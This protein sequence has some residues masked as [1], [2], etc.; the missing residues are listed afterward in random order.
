MRNIKRPSSSLKILTALSCATLALSSPAWAQT[1]WTSAGAT[2]DWTET[3]NWS[4]GLPGDS[5]IVNFDNSY[6]GGTGIPNNFVNTPFTIYGLNYSTISTNGFHHTFLAEGITLKV[7]NEVQDP[8]V[9]YYGA[10]IG[11]QTLQYRVSGPGTLSVSNS[12]G[13]IDV[14]QTGSDSDH[15]AI[16]DLT[17]L[18]N[19][20]ADVQQVRIAGTVQNAPRAMGR[21]I[22]ART[23]RIHTASSADRPGIVIGAMESSNTSLRGTQQL[24]LGQHNEIQSD[25]IS[26]GAHKSTGAMQFQSGLNTPYL[27]LRGSSGGPV[28]VLAMADQRAG[29][30]TM[31]RTGTSVNHSGTLNTSGGILD[32]IAIETFVGRSGTNSSSTSTGTLTYD[33]GSLTTDNLY[34]GYHTTGLPSSGQTANASGTVNV[35]GTAILNVNNNITL[36]R[37]LGSSNPTGN[38]N[39]A[40]NAVVN[41]K[42]SIEPSGSGNSSVNNSG[43]I[44]LQPEGDATKGN[45]ASGTLTGFGRVTNANTVTVYSTLSPGTGMAAGQLDI[46]GNF[47]FGNNGGYTFNASSAAAAG[48]DILKVTGG[49]TLASNLVSLVPLGASL[50]PGSYRLIEYQGALSGYL[51][52]V[53]GTRYNVDLD[54]STTNQI[55]LTVTGGSPESLKWNSASSS[56]WDSGTTNWARMGTGTADQ[57]F[58]Y[59]SVLFDS[60]PAFTNLVLLNGA[61]SPAAVTVDAGDRNYSFGGSGRLSGGASLIKRGTGMLTISNAN[62]FVGGVAVEAGVLRTINGSALGGTNEGTIVSSGATLDIFG[63][64]L[65]NPGESITIGGTGYTNQGAIVNT[66]PAQNNAIRFLTLTDDALITTAARW[67]VRGPS[68]SGSFSG[69]LDLNGHTLTKGGSAQFSIVDSVVTNAGTIELQ[70]GM[71]GLTRSTIGGSGSIKA[72]TNI[73]FLENSST[74]SIAK[75]IEFTGGTLRVGG[76]ATYLMEPVVSGL[77]ATV[78]DIISASGVTNIMLTMSNAITGPGDVIKSNTATLMLTAPS[79]FTG[80]TLVQNGALKLSAAGSVAASP[81]ITLGTLGSTGVLDVADLGTY[82]LAAGQKLG[83]RGIILGNLTVQNGAGLLPGASAGVLTFSNNLVLNASESVF[84]LGANPA[85]VG[86]DSDFV[87]V[88]GD[89]NLTGLNKIKIAPLATLDNSSP[90]T[91]F[92][93]TG[94][95]VGGIDNLEISSDSRYT[96]TPAVVG[97]TI[98]VTVSG[99]GS[100]ASLVWEGGVAGNPNLW[101]NK[102]VANW[103]R[104][105]TPDIF[106]LGDNVTFNDDASTGTVTVG[107]TVQPAAMAVDNSALAYV[108]NGAGTIVAGSLAKNGSGSL[109]IGNGGLAV[110]GETSLTQ[111]S[112]TLTAGENLFGPV[113]ISGGSFSVNNASSTFGSTVSLAGG[114]FTLNPP[115]DIYFGG[116]LVNPLGVGTGILVKQGTSTVTLGGDNNAYEGAINVLQG[117]LKLG[118]ATAL[119]ASNSGPTTVNGGT[120]DLNGQALYQLGESITISGMGLNSTGA[121]I[122]TGAAVQNGLS[123]ITL[124][125]NAAVGGTG[126]WDLRGPSGSSS[127]SAVLSLGTFTLSKVGPNQVGLVDAEISGDGRIDVQGGI[128][129][130]TRCNLN[131]GGYIQLNTNIL[132]LENYSSGSIT[133]PLVSSGGTLRVTGNAFR[134]DG[135]VTNLPGGLIVDPTVNITLAGTVQ[136]AGSL[137]KVNSGTL[138]LSALDNNWTGGTYINAGTLQVGSGPGNADGSIPNLP[139][140]NSGTLFFNSSGT[141]T[142][143]AEISGSGSLNKRGEYGVLTIT[144]SNSFTGNINTGTGTSGEAGGI[145]LLKNSYGFGNTNKTANIIRAE[146]QLDG[147]IRI[148]NVIAFAT[149]AN[150]DATDWAIGHVAIRNIGGDNIVDGP[151]TLTSGGG[152]S[153]FVSDAGTLTLNGDVTANSTGRDLILS[154]G[155]P[156]FLNGAIT[157]NGANIPRLVKRGTNTWTLTGQ[158]T[159]TGPTT[160][161]EGTLLLTSAASLAN[162]TG[163][164][165]WSNGVLNIVAVPAFTVAPNSVIRGEGLIQGSVTVDGEI[166]AGSG[167]DGVE[168]SKL[169]FANGLA[170]RGVTTLQIDRTNAPVADLLAVAGNLSLGGT[171]IVTN[172]GEPLQMGD[173]FNLFDAA[174][175][176][177]SFTNY[178]LPAL[179]P[180]MGWDLSKLA[181]DGTITVGAPTST[182][183]VP[184]VYQVSASGIEFTWPVDHKGWRLEAQTNSL[185]T[186]L[187]NNWSTVPGSKD[188]NRVILGIDQASGSVFYRLVYP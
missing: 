142:N 112:I 160:V 145:I 151:I 120:L 107:G 86:T 3:G 60:T 40:S 13:A 79:T 157:N 57:F 165:T 54:Y 148:P 31:Y 114:T 100:S 135:A 126:R 21:M 90:Y 149:S 33:Q 71:L 119:G 55:S 130:M 43:I 34:I 28:Q 172:L 16:L 75:V 92:R 63:S 144:T 171:L 139:V 73:V 87:E 47:V 81:K 14:T 78:F 85:L 8:L 56:T 25:I 143:T 102:G 111:G 132:L 155:A 128:L 164:D 159:F 52:F 181:V 162:S 89:L 74:G 113:T 124:A 103:L 69:R 15:F 12:A 50:Q 104:G 122:N 4:A 158:S 2:P 168:I 94:A 178:I 109:T 180:S 156:G 177:G 175:I 101:N 49:L 1:A 173:T 61:L 35:N 183:P 37:K 108:L 67:D 46:D 77:P 123:S 98:Q 185:T 70:Q 39:I 9:V 176:S 38:L 36:S 30:T 29:V 153:E 147:N 17:G 72:Y 48:N 11:S 170:L 179:D 127:L 187:T 96:F 53:N 7:L 131:G 121:V 140:V 83:G 110:G 95:L 163:F 166:R 116:Q 82:S 41:V 93:F 125:G 24:L 84:E 133:E 23:N 97:N 129:A 68:G 150:A 117:V 6:P 169:S 161:R 115:A 22:L 141:F 27:L 76:S 64:S 146:L 99:I 167:S 152:S 44:N 106:F 5:I 45:L 134:Y 137:T 184:L 66:G 62:D 154:G 138:I 136:G 18:T 32:A 51:R 19:F 26:I 88:I 59:D 105:T 20:T 65:Y 10:D 118:R 188:T 182:V 58:S 80:E 186:G 174:A 42:G 91:L